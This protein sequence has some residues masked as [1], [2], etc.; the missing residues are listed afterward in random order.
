[1]TGGHIPR[2]L[3]EKP[4]GKRS[5]E[6]IDDSPVT[7]VV[8]GAQHHDAVERLQPNAWTRSVSMHTGGERHV[9]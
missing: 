8:S 6:M 2:A 3:E 4:A 9:G 1:M 5:T 7:V